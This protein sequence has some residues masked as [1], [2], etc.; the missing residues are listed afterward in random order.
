MEYLFFSLPRRGHLATGPISAPSNRTQETSACRV[1]WVLGFGFWI[2]DW[3]CHPRA[4]RRRWATG[5][6]GL[7]AALLAVGA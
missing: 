3:S 2:G 7:G 6:P 5:R 4:W 1:F